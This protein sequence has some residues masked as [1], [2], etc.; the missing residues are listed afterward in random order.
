MLLIAPGEAKSILV[1]LSIGIM[2]RI[3]YR[4]EVK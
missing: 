3:V 1:L 4:V 2:L